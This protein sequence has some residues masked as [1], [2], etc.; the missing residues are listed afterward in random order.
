MRRQRRRS[1][2]LET[3]PSLAFAARRAHHH[4]TVGRVEGWI[5]QLD[6]GH[7]HHDS[8]R[9]H[10]D[11]DGRGVR[12]VR[13]SHAARTQFGPVPTLSGGFLP[14]DPFA[15]RTF[16]RGGLCGGV[17]V[18]GRYSCEP[19]SIAQRYRHVCC[20][21]QRNL[22][23]FFPEHHLLC[24]LRPTPFHD[25]HPCIPRPPEEPLLRQ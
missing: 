18:A 9:T 10:D 22:S 4:G 5:P 1:D 24:H 8:G 14:E 2:R 21:C 7:R 25:K 11:A 15:A 20:Y 23:L 19:M 17:L 13:A 16:E 3:R 12:R 6:R